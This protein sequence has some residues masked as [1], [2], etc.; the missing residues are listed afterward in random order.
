MLAQLM[1]W[2]AI[3]STLFLLAVW[4]VSRG[5]FGAAGVCGL[6]G[7][8]FFVSLLEPV[9]MVL[10]PAFTLYT[11]GSF[12]AALIVK[13]G[14][15]RP[16]AA[17]VAACV[18]VPATLGSLYWMSVRE[19]RRI[20]EFRE[21]YPVV[22][23][24]ERLAYEPSLDGERSTAIEAASHPQIT[25]EVEQRLAELEQRTSWSYR[26]FHLEA[27][28]DRTYDQFIRAS[29]F[30]NAR[31]MRFRHEEVER[32]ERWDGDP[33]P[34]PLPPEET[35]YGPGT[36]LPEL[37]AGAK[38]A[39][40]A[41]EAS[42]LLDMHAHGLHDFL[43]PDRIGWVREARQ[44]AGFL[45]HAFQRV[46]SLPRR[47][48]S[49]NDWRITRLELVS[50]LKHDTP[51]A[52]VSRDLPRMDELR[53]APTRPLDEFESAALP[54]LRREEDL[55]VEEGVNRI[56]MLGSVRA[57]NDCLQCHSVRRGELLGAFS[58]DLHRMRPIPVPREPDP[59]P[60]V[61]WRAG[62]ASV[63]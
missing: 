35:P 37:L 26:R 21:V 46:P 11:L 4:A 61:S 8:A 24:D 62:T 16:R 40:P 32:H 7:G 30:G 54:R 20:A 9:I 31:M 34:L 28:H 22:S 15:F 63:P 42:A 25:A 56:R 12:V 59:L 5:R 14:R 55:V 41:P 52:Y 23:L 29:G 39:A 53:D 13:F 10:S 1:L 2:S 47:E 60:A 51:V 50:L 27:L 3:V 48:E 36:P 44:A 57:G 43:D 49:G 18:I 6:T 45:P 17:F 33:A 58:Y 19:A 38:N